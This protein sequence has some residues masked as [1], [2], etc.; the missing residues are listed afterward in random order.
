MKKKFTL[1]EL[2]VVVAVFGILAS[3]LLPSLRNA[4]RASLS[5]VC[6]SNLRQL[7]TFSMIFAQDHNGILPHSYTNNSG[8]ANSSRYFDNTYYEK[9]VK[10]THFHTMWKQYDMPKQGLNC[11]QAREELLPRWTGEG[12]KFCDYGQNWF[13]GAHKS[14]GLP[15]VY[16]L[17]DSNYI[18][19]DGYIYS[20]VNGT[21][22]HMPSFIRLKANGNGHLPWMID[23]NMY[24]ELYGHQKQSVNFLFGDIHVS[25]K[26][27][28]ELISISSDK[29][30]ELNGVND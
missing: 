22:Y 3:L 13:M 6:M 5:A 30:D 21:D 15:K 9:A 8:V 16:K 2:L 1:I 11:P 18:Y 23:D 24:P 25:K 29:V 19:S 12:N 10:Y 4:R 17:K 27:R 14:G 28:S 20:M 7:G 26:Y